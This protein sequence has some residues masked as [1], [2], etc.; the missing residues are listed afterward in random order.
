MADV[1]ARF[2]MP[3]MIMRGKV[4]GAGS[5]VVA[6]VGLIQGTLLSHVRPASR[7]AQDVF[8]RE[9]GESIGLTLES[10]TSFVVVIVLKLLVV[11]CER[12]RLAMV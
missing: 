8:W 10:L 12:D 4:V 3:S 7:R 5:K 1:N 9:V 11:Q 6:V 2:S